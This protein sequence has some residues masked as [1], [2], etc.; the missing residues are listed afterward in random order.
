MMTTTPKRTP[1]IGDELQTLEVF[2]IQEAAEFLKVGRKAI[3]Q[4]I[5]HRRLKVIQLT[6]SR[7]A[8]RIYRKDLLALADVVR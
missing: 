5:Q 7:R 4:A 8:L 2:T 3:T 1:R 6:K